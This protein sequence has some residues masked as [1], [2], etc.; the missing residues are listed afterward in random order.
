MSRI[1]FPYPTLFPYVPGEGSWEAT[2]DGTPRMFKD[3]SG[4]WDYDSQLDVVCRLPW[5]PK[6]LFEKAGLEDLLEGARLA[7]VIATGAS[8]GIGRRFIATDISIQESEQI[9]DEGTA[10]ISFSVDSVRICNRLKVSLFIYSSG[11]NIG[12]IAILNGSVLYREDTTLQLEGDLAS[13][14]IRSLDFA[15]SNLGDGFWLVD[16]EAESLEDPLI[17]SVTLLLN[18]SRPDFIEQLQNES[19]N[20]G[21]LRWAVRADVMA[22]VL[23]WLLNNEEFGFDLTIQCPEGSIGAAA[24]AWLRGLGMEGQSDIQRIR[25]TMVREPG[26][27]RQRCQSV[28]AP[29]EEVGS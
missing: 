21:S 9:E 10:T 17:S 14:P 20:T 11:G 8:E 23:T 16:C 15:S 18:T 5:A 13:F 12:G 28:C 25:D 3:G 24:T 22:T 4:S 29:T 6:E 27:F 7:V 26:Q 2:I 19:P 1:A